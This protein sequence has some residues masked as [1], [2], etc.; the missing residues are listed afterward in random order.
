MS[1]GRSITTAFLYPS[2]SWRAFASLANDPHVDT[3]LADCRRGLGCKDLQCS[4]RKPGY[5]C[6]HH[7]RL[8]L[9]ERGLLNSNR[10][11]RDGC[12]N[13]QFQTSARDCVGGFTYINAGCVRH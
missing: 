8:P 4:H 6:F 12:A 2:F 11:E 10:A 13:W 1:T 9:R 7:R 5:S 3:M